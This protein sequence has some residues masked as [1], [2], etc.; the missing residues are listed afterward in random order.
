[1]KANIR[2]L[3]FIILAAMLSATT[4]L[5]DLATLGNKAIIA[6][7][8]LLRYTRL[9][10]FDPHRKDFVCADASK[11]APPVDP[12]AERWFQQAVAINAL[13]VAAGG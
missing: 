7:S 5:A 10:P 4:A 2:L 9:P 1:M 12:Q 13:A 3:V 8:G 11:Y 6:Q